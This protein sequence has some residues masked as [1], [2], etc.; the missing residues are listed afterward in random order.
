MY[1]RGAGGW[2]HEA[3]VLYGECGHRDP[4]QRR[5][6]FYANLILRENPF[7]QQREG[8]RDRAAQ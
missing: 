3:Y 4:Q 6:V 8:L 2:A 5:C 1:I 7:Q